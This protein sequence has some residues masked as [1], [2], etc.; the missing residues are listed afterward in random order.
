MMPSAPYD[1]TNSESRSTGGKGSEQD[2]RIKRHKN[3]SNNN[4][5]I[6]KSPSVKSMPPKGDLWFLVFRKVWRIGFVPKLCLLYHDLQKFFR[7]FWKK[8]FAY[9]FPFIILKVTYILIDFMFWRK[10]II[11]QRPWWWKSTFLGISYTILFRC[12]FLSVL[13]FI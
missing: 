13:V 5:F 3:G 12:I 8:L 9:I 10:N 6:K 2:E 1:L 7:F 11:F 4:F